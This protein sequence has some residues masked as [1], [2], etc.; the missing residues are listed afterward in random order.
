[1]PGRHLANMLEGGTTPLL[2]PARL[3]E[4]GYT[5]VAYPL[6]LLAASVRAMQ[7]ALG[8]LGAGADPSSRLASFSDLRRLVGFDTYDA[9][10]ERYR[11]A[12]D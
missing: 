9:E 8:D 5:L 4:L 10:S 12:A 3:G 6:T 2:P 11:A 7:A 1:M